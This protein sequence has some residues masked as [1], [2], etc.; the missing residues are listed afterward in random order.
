VFQALA[1]NQG[2]TIQPCSEP[3]TLEWPGDSATAT[4]LRRLAGAQ[5][6]LHV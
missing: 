6:S 3:A 5:R 2:R 4:G 1:A